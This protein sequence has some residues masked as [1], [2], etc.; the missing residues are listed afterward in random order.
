YTVTIFLVDISPSMGAM[1]TVDLPPGPK[2]EQG[3]VEMTNLEWSMQFVKLKI[4]EMIF[5]GR[6][7]DQCGVIV[8]GSEDTDN[9]INDKSGGYEHV[10]EYIPV[11]QPNAGTLTKL[12]ALSPSEVTGDPVDALIV[13]IETQDQYLSSKRT[14]T[15]K[16]VLLTDGENPIEIEDWEATVQKMDSLSIAL[17]VVGVD[18]DD[19]E[20][21]FEE[22][23]KSTIKVLLPRYN[24]SRYPSDSRINRLRM[25]CFTRS[26]QPLFNLE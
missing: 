14:W 11:A 21:P 9:V 4:Q 15:R 10:S 12:D 19:E 23:N 22:E 2:G 18:F 5:N 8:F 16:I 1:R 24:E 25:S 7:T 3:T 26:S 13:G 17:T 20:L 6:K